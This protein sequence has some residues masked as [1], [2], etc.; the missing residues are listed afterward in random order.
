MKNPFEK[1]IKKIEECS[2]TVYEV[3]FVTDD[4]YCN[5]EDFARST[6]IIIMI[7]YSIAYTVFLLCSIYF[8]KQVT[9]QNFF[10]KVNSKN[11]SL[12]MKSFLIY[13][14]R[15]NHLKEGVE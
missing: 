15:G 10:K 3:K 5:Q 4:V 9:P 7:L 14:R 6:K 1:T 2:H 13:E 11:C 12:I 8:F